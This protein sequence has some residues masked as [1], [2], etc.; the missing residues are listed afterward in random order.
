MGC[1]GAL[2][3]Y[4]CLQLATIIATAGWAQKWAGWVGVETV[5]RRN[6]GCSVT[7]ILGAARSNGRGQRTHTI[8]GHAAVK[9]Y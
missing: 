9:H 3:V 6:W 2:R 1:C 5:R 4:C 7:S 8:L